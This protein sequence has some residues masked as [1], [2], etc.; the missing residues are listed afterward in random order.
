VFPFQVVRWG[1]SVFANIQKFVQ[2]QLTI[3]VVALTVNFV[4]AVASGTAP[5]TVVQVSPVTSGGDFV[6][7][8]EHSSKFA[9]LL[10][11]TIVWLAVNFH[12]FFPLSDGITSFCVCEPTSHI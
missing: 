7:V 12:H 11:L 6:L 9:R 10:Q 2:F 5:L 1:R 4:S 3:N 8:T